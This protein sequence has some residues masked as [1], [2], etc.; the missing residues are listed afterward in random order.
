MKFNREI[1]FLVFL[2]ILTLFLRLYWIDLNPLEGDQVRDIQTSEKILH[3]EFATSGVKEIYGLQTSFGPLMFYLTAPFLL[4]G[5][6]GANLA[7][8]IFNA[9]AVL[10]TYF[11]TR[12]FFGDKVAVIASLLYAVNPW[13]IY[14]S[15]TY[16]NPNF[17]PFF[18]VIFFYFLFD[19]ILNNNDNSLVVASLVLSLMFQ[20]HLTSLFLLPVLFLS[21]LIFR[22]NTKIKY[23]FYSFGVFLI[24]LI[25][26]IY[27]NFK[28]NTSIFSPFI[29]GAYRESSSL[30]TSFSETFGLPIMLATNYL[31][32]YVYGS[33]DI[34]GSTFLSY[35]FLLLTILFV[36]IFIASIIYLAYKFK[37]DKN[38]KY[39]LLLLILFIPSFLHFIRFSGISPH[40]FF[41]LYPLQFVSIS[42]FLSSIYTR[43]KI[44]Y[45]KIF[46]ASLVLLTFLFI[47]NS[48]LFFN[49][50]DKNGTTS[51]GQ[52][53]IT[54]DTKI[55]ILNYISNQPGSEKIVIPHVSRRTFDYLIKS[56]YPN[57][58]FYSVNNLSEL[59]KLNN[60][61]LI[62]D[63]KSAYRVFLNPQD[64]EYLA[65]L[66]KTSIKKVDVYY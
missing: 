65:K 14:L 48:Y 21:I 41:V 39:A 13:H 26:Y 60:F 35:L 54:Y 23:Y 36:I 32:K 37:I 9:L 49:Y 22:R 52:V 18:S 57:L 56:K 29:Y 19:Y 58:K 25:P 17:L 59:Q 7:V 28:T 63:N 40:Y 1:L 38:K 24:T 8:A 16:W 34:F 15:I 4:F 47:F 45:R 27:Y 46:V 10:L 64:E 5:A 42:I 55:E 33:S 20:F 44:N 2:V 43:L 51:G 61:Y 53:G 11:F 12:K 62:I 6:I 30:I 31:G 3:G 66:N 50:L